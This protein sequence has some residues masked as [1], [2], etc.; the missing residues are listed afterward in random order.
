MSP[1]Y[2]SYCSKHYMYYHSYRNVVTF[3]ITVIEMF[4][5]YGYYI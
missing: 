5:Y 3:T 1:H 2:N 4:G